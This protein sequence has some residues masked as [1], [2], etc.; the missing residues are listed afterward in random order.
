MKIFLFAALMGLIIVSTGCVTSPR[1]FPP[2]GNIQN[3]DRV[4]SKLLRGAQFNHEGLDF[5]VG[6]YSTPT[7]PLTVINFRQG[8]DVWSDEEP[9]CAK[10]GIHYV[11]SPLSPVM[12]PHKIDVDMALHIINNAPGMVYVHCQYGCDRT[13]TVVACY[14]IRQGMSNEDAL[15]DAKKHGMSSLELCMENFVK[16]FK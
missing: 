8:N 9:L 10:H 13:G 5:L 11:N 6:R 3:F 4:D 16:H 12:A 14:R 1:G 15:N 7:K 2:T